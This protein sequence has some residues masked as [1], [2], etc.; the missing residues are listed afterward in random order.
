MKSNKTYNLKSLEASIRANFEKEQTNI[1]LKD[2]PFYPLAFHSEMPEEVDFEN[3]HLSFRFNDFSLEAKNINLIEE[4]CKFTNDSIHLSIKM[5]EVLLKSFY[6]I[7]AQQANKIT[8][9]TGGNMRELDE[10]YSREAGAESGNVTPLSPTEINNMVTQARDQKTPIQATYH[11]PT[12]MTS[13]NEHSESYNTAF[14]T[15]SSLRTLWADGGSTTEMSR[16]TCD[17]LT[18][19]TVVNSKIKKYPNGLTYNFSAAQQQVNVSMALQIMAIKAKNE[20]NKVLEAKYTAAAKAAAEFKQTTNDTGDGSQPANMTGEEVYQH[21]DN[22]SAKIKKMSDAEYKNL[23]DQANS[24]ESK[25]G[26]ANEEAIKNGWKVLTDDERK[27]MRHRMFL[28]SEEMMALKDIKPELLWQG[29][30]T[31]DLSGAEASVSLNYDESNSNWRVSKSE[32]TLPAFALELDDSFWTG[33]TAEIVRDRLS[34]ISFVKS[35][36]QSKIKAAIEKVIE[37]VTTNSISEA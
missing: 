29:D 27:L 35:L 16:D 11:G 12:L 34:N 21:L 36:L 18:N 2:T 23:L 8:L 26:G 1:Q 6:E 25:E 24:D 37:S 5:D 4:D 15:S 22:K 9:D 3:G 31:A 20:G 7:N 30:C 13:Y 14:V 17:A 10:S 19:K 32:V 28:F 33:K